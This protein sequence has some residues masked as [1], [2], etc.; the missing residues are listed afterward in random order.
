MHV[1]PDY[2]LLARLERERWKREETYVCPLWDWIEDFRE[3][4]A[5][6]GWW[7][8]I[9]PETGYNGEVRLGQTSIPLDEISG[10][11]NG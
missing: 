8:R 6:E 4:F 5:R 10:D 7:Q 2:I 9:P 11:I 1:F 3:H